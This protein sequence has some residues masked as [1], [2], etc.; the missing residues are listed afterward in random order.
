[1]EGE[2]HADIGP[3]YEGEVIRKEDLYIEFGGPKVDYKFERATVK[4]LEEIENEKVE[5]IGPDISDLQPYDAEK[6]GGSYPIAI[7]VDVAGGELDK[8]AEAII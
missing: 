3:Q 6:G 5:I 1:M 7:L 2:F 4:P 8:D